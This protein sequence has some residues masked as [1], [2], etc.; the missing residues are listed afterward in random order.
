MLVHAFQSTMKIARIALVVAAFAG[1]S[2]VALGAFGAHAL[3]N[4]LDERALA[5]WRIAV[6]YQFWHA[7][8]LFG[9]AL[10]ARD[11]KLTRALRIAALAFG[12]GIVLFCASLY[13]LALGAPHWI[14]AIT[15]LGGALFIVGWI[16]LGVAA[17]RGS[18]D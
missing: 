13:V 5:T 15:P 12:V 10:L 3:R 11:A 4:V 17:W 7:L 8:A 1:A 14:G 6:D 18:V 9:T 2:A 16:A